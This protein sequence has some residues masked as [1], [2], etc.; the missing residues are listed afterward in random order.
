M[1]VLVYILKK[2]QFISS[3]LDLFD[4]NFSII[5]SIPDWLSLFCSLISGII[6]PMLLYYFGQKQ[7]KIRE[8]ELKQNEYNNQR[9]VSIDRCAKL[10]SKPMVAT[11]SKIDIYVHNSIQIIDKYLETNCVISD[12]AEINDYR[13]A[14]LLQLTLSFKEYS[15][16]NI[17][18]FLLEKLEIF[19]SDS[20]NYY[21]N[22]F[23][24]NKN[25]DSKYKEVFFDSDNS[26]LTIYIYTK[27][28]NT[29]N[30]ILKCL[31]SCSKAKITLEAKMI[32]SF[33][34]ET[35]GTWKLVLLKEQ[36]NNTQNS[37]TFNFS[38]DNSICQ[39][40]KII[41]NNI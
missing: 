12:M 4:R 23:F 2:F 27:I 1:N 33:N 30:N 14:K 29:T 3:I 26:L 36:S 21:L 17:S 10:Y 5:G 18:S 24:Y 41:D 35:S 19:F 40:A 31:N 13:N 32:N 28:G 16:I 7:Q 8:E 9:L 15:I 20:S 39:I 6:I 11:S 34:I 37:S 38:V 25:L 22:S